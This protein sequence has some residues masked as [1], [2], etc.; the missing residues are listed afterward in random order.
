MGE[1]W[2]CARDG[3]AP[4]GEHRTTT[5]RKLCPRDAKQKN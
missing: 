3:G 2:D 1:S 5:V 4:S